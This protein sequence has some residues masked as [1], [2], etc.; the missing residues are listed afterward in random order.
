MLEMVLCFNFIGKGGNFQLD[1]YNVWCTDGD[2][3]L[4]CEKAVCCS[5][6]HLYLNTG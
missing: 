1:C 6:N 3:S 5:G 2:A 4:I